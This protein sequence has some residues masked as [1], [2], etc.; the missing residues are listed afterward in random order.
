MINERMRELGAH[1][2]AIREIFEYARYL[3]T[4]SKERRRSGRKMSLTF[5]LEIRV[6]PHPMRLMRS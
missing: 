6:Y 1:R 2:S 3:N 4:A 5:R